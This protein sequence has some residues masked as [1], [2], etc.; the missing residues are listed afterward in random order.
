MAKAI[1]TAEEN[2][3][4]PRTRNWGSALVEIVLLG[5]VYIAVAPAF[6]RSVDWRAL[7]PASFSQAESATGAG[8]LAGAV[9]QLVL[10]AAFAVMFKTMRSAIKGS[11]QFGTAAAWG[12]ALIACV[13]H[14]T[15]LAAFFIDDPARILEASERNLI[16]SIAP[17]ADGWSQEVMF[18]G[19]VIYRLAQSGAP[20][21]VQILTSAILFAAIHFGFTGNDPWSVFWPLFGTAVLGGFLAWSVRLGN[22]ALMPAVVCHTLLI[23]II[24]PW[25]SLNA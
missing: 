22:G 24:Q 15:T 1:T 3:L 11:I 6:V 25:L 7:F 13:I 2:P 20:A 10:V 21:V 16:L 9:I 4:Y 5:L 19:Y 14:A 17:A 18:R 12:A 8:F 23:I